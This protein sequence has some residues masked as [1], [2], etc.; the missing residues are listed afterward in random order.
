[1]KTKRECFKR[2]TVTIPAS[3]YEALD[4]MIRERG[5]GNRS[6]VISHLVKRE[7][8]RTHQEDPDR[9]MAGT[10]TLTYSEERNSCANRLISLRR[11]NLEEVISTQQVMLEGGLLMETWLVQG[12]VRVLRNML[13]EALK[14]SPGMKGELNFTD[15]L[16][17]PVRHNKPVPENNGR[18]ENE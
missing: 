13:S 11:A 14:C 15:A 3:L 9:I 6:W 4:Q 1:M 7:V 16:M 17:P 5:M 8:I 12:E 18:K 10:I 2:F